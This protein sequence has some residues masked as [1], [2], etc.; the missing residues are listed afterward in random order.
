MA[1]PEPNDRERE[2][3]AG[4]LN[5]LHQMYSERQAMI[6]QE[7]R[8]IVSSLQELN[9]VLNS[10]SMPEQIRNKESLMHVG[11]DVYIVGKVQDFDTVIVGVGGEYMVEKKVEDA[12]QFV[13]ARAEKYNK[14]LQ[15][16]MKEREELEAALTEVA[17]K[18]ETLD[19]R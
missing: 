12:K 1:A 10:L 6:S 13:S 9:N 14:A 3:A 5:Y 7:I 15:T 19:W 18:M 2:A 8:S 4:Q 17:Y 16:L 11:S